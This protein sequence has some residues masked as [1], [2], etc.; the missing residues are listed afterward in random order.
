MTKNIFLLFT[1]IFILSSCN[2]ITGMNDWTIDDSIL[3]TDSNSETDSTYD[4][5]SDSE[6]DSTFDSDTVDNSDSD[7]NTSENTKCDLPISGDQFNAILESNSISI[8]AI[9]TYT[10]DKENGWLGQ[11]AIATCTLKGWEWNNGAVPDCSLALCAKSELLNLPEV[12][13]SSAIADELPENINWNTE[14]EYTCDT[15]NYVGES[16]LAICTTTGWAWKTKAPDCTLIACAVPANNNEET[17]N[18]NTITGI[19]DK[20]AIGETCTLS[21][22]QG[23]EIFGTNPMTCKSDGTWQRD[24]SC[25]Y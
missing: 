1:S 2:Q 9:A 21:C 13:G 17:Y 3:E 10:C 24:V 8:N 14:V 5:D 15:P 11:T 19:P 4:S 25:T 20:V 18:C 23:F 12:A 7:S 6:T 22:S 16:V